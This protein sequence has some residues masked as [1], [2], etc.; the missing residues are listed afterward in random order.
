MNLQD[1]VPKEKGND[2]NIRKLKKLS[3]EEIQPIIP[4]L[5][6]WLQ[7]INW[8][9]LNDVADVLEP[10]SDKLTPYLM[11]IFK[12]NDGMWKYWILT[13]FGRETKD[14]VFLKEI[15]RIATIPTR[16][17]IDC[18]VDMEAQAI[19]NRDYK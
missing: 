12:T 5:L 13:I 1:L 8:P 3:F 15:N 7:D 2:S 10:F 11:E 17:E 9:I 16:D 14:E 19:L 18:E 6:E 4:D